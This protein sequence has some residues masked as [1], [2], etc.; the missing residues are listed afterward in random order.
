MTYYVKLI[1]GRLTY[2]PR[3]IKDGDTIVYNPTAEHLL[4]LGYKP[5]RIEPM[6]EVE[7]G[8]HL[9][10]AYTETDTEVVQDWTV[11]EDPPV[12]PDAEEILDILLGGDA[13]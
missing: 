8:Y 3:K 6:P 11:V 7:E 9:E 4:P 2:A 1:D 10:P 12:E 5:L 13:E